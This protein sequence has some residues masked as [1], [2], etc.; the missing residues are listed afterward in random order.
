MSILST[1]NLFSFQLWY[2]W[3]RKHTMLILGECEI[4]L[5]NVILKSEM[6]SGNHFSLDYFCRKLYSLTRTWPISEGWGVNIE[7]DFHNTVRTIFNNTKWKHYNSTF[8]PTLILEIVSIYKAIF[9][10]TGLVGRN[11][12]Q[13]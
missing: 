12:C 11:H 7:F 4:I 2:I 5:K 3:I 8:Y 13:Q 1:Y 9:W 6:W 10:T